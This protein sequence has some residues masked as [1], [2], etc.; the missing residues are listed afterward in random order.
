MTDY[1]FII[2]IG[3]VIIFFSMHKSSDSK[4]DKGGEKGGKGGKE[5]K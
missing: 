2:A 1:I 3:L 5:K 4:G